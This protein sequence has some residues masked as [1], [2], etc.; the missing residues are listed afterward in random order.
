[1]NKSSLPRS[2]FLAR[3]FLATIF[4]LPAAIALALILVVPAYAAPLFSDLRDHWAK[5]AVVSLAAKG[6]VEGYPDG[7]FKGDRAATRWEVALMVARLLARMEQ[8]HATFATKADLETLRALVNELRSEL[9]V[10]GVRVTNLEENV[11]K[12]D[13]RV[14]ALEKI[15]FYGSVDTYFVSQGFQ[16]RGRDTD[17]AG[18]DYNV[19]VGAAAG[20]PGWFPFA[21]AA[22]YDANAYPF[23]ITLQAGGT[24]TGNVGHKFPVID[25]FSGTPLTNGT[26]FSGLGILGTRIRV[27]DDISAGA[28]FAAFMS[29]GDSVVDLWYGSSANYLSNGFT[30]Q[31]Q[32]AGPQFQNNTPFTRMTLDNFWVVHNP[33]GT[34]VVLGAFTDTNMDR[35]VLAN[36]PNPNSNG[37]DHLPWYG[38]QLSGSANILSTM[39]WEVLGT[40]LPDDGS[41]NNLGGYYNFALAFNLDWQ[42]KG[43]DFKLNFLRA[44]NDDSFG[45][46]RGGPGG[47]G[48]NFMPY[49]GGWINPSGY[50]AAAE[51]N[52]QNRPIQAGDGTWGAFGP[53]GLTTWGASLHYAFDLPWKLAFTGEYATSAYKPN[54]GSGYSTSGS[55]ARFGLEARLAS[56]ALQ[57]GLEFL[58]VEPRFDPFIVA[59]PITTGV[60]YGYWRLP[61]LSYMADLYS[62]HDTEVYPHNR[63]GWKFD[64]KYRFP[65]SEAG[66]YGQYRDLVQKEASVPDV[67]NFAVATPYAPSIFFGSG[68]GFSPGFIEAVFPALLM[69]PTYGNVATSF[70]P[71]ESPLGKV[72]NWGL[73]LDY[74]FPNH[75]LGIELSYQDYRFKR[76]SNLGNTI[77]TALGVVANPNYLDL[78]INQGHIGLSYP[79]SDRFTLLGGYDFAAIR[80][81]FMSRNTNLDTRQV[82]PYLGFNYQIAENTNW[83][84]NL[85]TYN[86]S[87]G[88]GNDPDNGFTNGPFE[89][90][91]SQLSTGLSVSF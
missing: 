32:L 88:I 25:Y 26:G 91:G 24:W 56:D 77:N 30:G 6:I 54:I 65:G 82:A 38:F 47:V 44:A 37:P 72:I 74:R 29:Q 45:G 8:E 1:V 78:S 4:S 52:V 76:D 49:L 5:D 18:T 10:L 9:D 90:S 12:L 42:F 86:V 79:C 43:G 53:Q 57:L 68:P 23:G 70:T 87:D 34:R 62:L 55:A 64:F 20:V 40:R 13:Q 2:F 3:R 59:Y 31:M 19:Q 51:P 22:V 58:S 89:W 67:A 35:L 21:G 41:F 14:T 85:K 83:K 11:G 63:Q 61:S 50:S 48:F 84:L 16:N 60:T 39:K 75:R 27:S 81:A 28:E 33:T 36:V 7:T 15:T 66:L 69:S 73:G 46:A 71:L 80:G 17:S